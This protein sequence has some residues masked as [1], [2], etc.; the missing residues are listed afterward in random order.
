MFQNC[1]DPIISV[2]LEVQYKYSINNQ[3]TA[4]QCFQWPLQVMLLVQDI[5]WDCKFYKFQF[6]IFRIFTNFNAQSHEFA[7]CDTNCSTY[8]AT[9]DTV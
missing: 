8:A 1:A 4:V 9:N 6:F 7:I 2:W 5:H 3:V